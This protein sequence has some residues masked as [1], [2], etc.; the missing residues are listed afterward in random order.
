MTRVTVWVLATLTILV[1]AFNYHTS[2]AGP[3]KRAAKP[4]LKTLVGD[5]VKVKGGMVQVR[6]A[7]SGA[8]MTA[9]D[10]PVYPSANRDTRKHSEHALS[11]LVKETLAAQSAKIEPVSGAAALSKGYRKSLR[12]ALE[13]AGL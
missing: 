8:T 4:A 1:L 2:T 3:L 6:I 5:K 11:Q 13:K 7:V 12:T 10:V 9:V